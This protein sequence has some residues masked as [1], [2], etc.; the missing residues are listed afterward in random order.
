MLDSKI[1]AV[2]LRYIV[3]YTAEFTVTCNSHQT[4]KEVMTALQRSRIFPI[5][6]EKFP[7]MFKA[8]R[9]E[10]VFVNTDIYKLISEQ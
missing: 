4:Q 7:V 6:A 10:W 8:K 5:S 9:R 3:C 1:T 2:P